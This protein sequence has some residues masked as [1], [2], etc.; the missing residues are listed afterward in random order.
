MWRE[1]LETGVA[2]GEVGTVKEEGSSRDGLGHLSVSNLQK[3]RQIKLGSQV[4]EFISLY[5]NYLSAVRVIKK[6]PTEERTPS[7]EY[8]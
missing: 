3:R 2:E 4:K 5:R 1:K 6:E 7:L 8:V